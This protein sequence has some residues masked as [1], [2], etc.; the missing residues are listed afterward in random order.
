MFEQPENPNDALK[1]FETVVAVRD[2]CLLQF[3][4]EDFEDMKSS[5]HKI[6]AG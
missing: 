1:R 5:V 2:S 4:L 6:G 3:K